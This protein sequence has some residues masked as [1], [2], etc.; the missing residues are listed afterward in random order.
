MKIQ[1]YMRFSDFVT[2]SGICD[3]QNFWLSPWHLPEV[4]PNILKHMLCH[5]KTKLSTFIHVHKVAMLIFELNITYFGKIAR[6]VLTILSQ[7]KP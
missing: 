3:Y 4:T 2:K 1:K 5:F 7:Y 6:I